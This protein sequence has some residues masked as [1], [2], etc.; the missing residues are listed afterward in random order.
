MPTKMNRSEQQPY[1]P[2]GEDGGEYRSYGF[3]GNP[4]P[5][6]VS[7]NKKSK[8]KPKM[9]EEDRQFIEER[10]GEKVAPIEK[11]IYVKKTFEELKKDNDLRI[12][13][14]FDVELSYGKRWVAFYG[15]SDKR[16]SF[17]LTG[18]ETEKAVQVEVFRES[19]DGEY[20]GSQLVWVP[21]KA[22]VSSKY[23]RDFQQW[24]EYRLQR[25]MEEGFN[26][27][28]RVQELAIKY[29]I[30]PKD[31]KRK[32]SIGWFANKFAEIGKEQEIIDI[33][34]IEKVEKSVEFNSRMKM[35]RDLIKIY[36][37]THPRDERKTSTLQYW[38][39]KKLIDRIGDAEL[40]KEQQEVITKAKGYI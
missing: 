19:A 1:V 5:K 12:A 26:N 28:L 32:H 33:V 23:N 13:D 3:G 4:I 14:W 40:T 36:K 16:D 15:D 9:T 39:Y 7:E 18:V 21:K 38:S 34:G 27:Y 2:S 6:K 30:I 20:D 24:R 8:I 35:H 25:A 17:S 10:I 29:N 31:V 11:S 37:S 22:F